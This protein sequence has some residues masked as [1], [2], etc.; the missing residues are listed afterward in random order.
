[1]PAPFWRQAYSVFG[2]ESALYK[3]YENARKFD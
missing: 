1:M 3:T 2:W